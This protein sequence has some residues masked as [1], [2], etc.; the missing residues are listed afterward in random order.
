MIYYF[1]FILILL[2]TREFSVF[3]MYTELVGLNIYNSNLFDMAIVCAN[4][5]GVGI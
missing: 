2:I 3:G 4:L 1:A 5:N